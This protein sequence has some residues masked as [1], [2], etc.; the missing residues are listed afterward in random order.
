MK[1]T[2]SDLLRA[3]LW[4]LLLPAMLIAVGAFVTGIT[5]GFALWNW[6]DPWPTIL[7]LGLL[8]LP[9]IILSTLKLSRESRSALIWGFL[10]CWGLVGIY[11]W[12][13]VH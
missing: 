6:H 9:A 3:S 10:G 13:I 4:L 8:A 1:I 5:F 7:W 12:S 2:Y 11:I